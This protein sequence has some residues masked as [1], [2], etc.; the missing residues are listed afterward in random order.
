MRE[1]INENNKELFVIKTINILSAEQEFKSWQ[2]SGM[3]FTSK[4]SWSE[5]KKY[6]CIQKA[7]IAKSQIV[8]FAAHLA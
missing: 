6:S 5:K 3:K 4:Q 7:F 2:D 1:N 8:R